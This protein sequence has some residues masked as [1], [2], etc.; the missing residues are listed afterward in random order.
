MQGFIDLDTIAEISVALIGF[1]AIVAMLR[2]GSLE[3]WSP[4]ARFG[5]WI[6]LSYGVGGIVFSLL[7]SIL[8]DLELVSWLFCVLCLAAFHVITF[9]L[10]LRRHSALSAAGHPTT[11]VVAWIILSSVSV[12]AIVALVVGAAGYIGGP[13]YR[14]YHAGV[15]ACVINS[16]LAFVFS[17]RMRNP[18]A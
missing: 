14:L 1:A 12:A 7:P 18:A 8:L 5:F 2:E 3:T 9:G 4:R 10:H 16:V 6:I 11:S 15:V 13:S 17:L